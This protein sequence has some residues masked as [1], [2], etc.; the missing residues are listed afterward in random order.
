MRICLDTGGY[1]MVQQQPF[2]WLLVGAALLGVGARVSIAPVTWIWLTLLLHASSSLPL[3]RGTM[4]IWMALFAALAFG[5]RPSM[6]IPAAAYFGIAGTIATTAVVP[7][8][9]NRTFAPRLDGV[10]ATLVFPAAWVAME[11]L[12]SRFTPGATWGSIAYTQFGNVPL[13]QLAAFVG[14]WGVA[15]VV[16]WFASVVELAWSRGFDWSVIRAPILTYVAVLAVVL[17]TGAARAALAPTNGRILRAAMLNRPLDLF[18]PGEITRISEGRISAEERPKFGDK[19]R[20][21]HDWFLEG[22]RREARAGARL[23]VW[24]EQ[25]LLVFEEDEA[26]FLDRAQRL[27]ADERVYLAMGMATIHIGEK[28]PFENKLVIIDSSGRIVMSYRKSHPVAGWEASIMK[29]GDGRVPVIATADGRF[30][31]AICFDADFPEF[32]RQAALSDAHLLIIPANDWKAIK[33]IHFQMAAF[34][35]VETGVPIVRAAA[36]GISTAVDAWGRVLAV[37]DYFAR[38]D[39][40]TTAQVPVGR[41]RTMYGRI[42]DSF[43]WLCIVGVIAL[44]LMSV[45]RAAH[46]RIA[47][48][49]LTRHVSSAATTSTRNAHA[50]ADGERSSLG[51]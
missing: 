16:A 37:G 14:I 34:R 17:V 2:V 39:G 23:I 31:G 42:G 36:S 47:A 1:R 32:I 13:M 44:A 19:L 38:G 8:L 29:V 6:P 25:N 20:R 4:L 26:A 3:T 22:S 11:F 5:L 35:A 50:N 24:P 12:R 51:A 9:L 10:S 18:I 49:E 27:A 15:F 21:L 40:T 43:A 45:Y 41:V 30:A 7:F 48:S 28:L 33:T 46:R